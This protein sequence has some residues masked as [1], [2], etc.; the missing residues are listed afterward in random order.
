MLP[1][2]FDSSDDL[3]LP[4]WSEAGELGIAGWESRAVG[5]LQHGPGS[6]PSREGRQG[7]GTGP[8]VLPSYISDQ[9]F[10]FR[11]LK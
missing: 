8:G 10:W 7:S 4:A 3:A 6:I 2:T 11:M 5:I 9:H 1:E